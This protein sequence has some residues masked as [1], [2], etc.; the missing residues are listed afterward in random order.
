MND[1]CR[2]GMGVM[3]NMLGPMLDGRTDEEPT[4]ALADV[5]GLTIASVILDDDK[6]G[7]D[8]ALV[9]T[10]TDGRALEVFDKGRSCCE[11]RY[12]KCDDDLDFYGGSEFQDIAIE[13]GG[14]EEGE[15]GDCHETQFLLVHTSKGI[16]TVNTHNEHNGYYGGFWLVADVLHPKAEGTDT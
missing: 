4:D 10:F 2:L 15:Y 11:S 1:N 9:F 16:F 7:G 13:C 14:T 5:K 3:L 12:L 8:G 6:N